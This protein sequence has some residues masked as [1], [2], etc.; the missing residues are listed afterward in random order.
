MKIAM[1]G[2]KGI[3]A[4]S[5]GVERYTENLSIR[6][7]GL[8]HSVYVYTRPYY[9][10]K[11]QKKHKSVNL[12]SIPSIHTKHLD[13]I[14]HTLFSSIHALFQNYD[15]IHY[16]GVGPS[17]LAWIPRIFKPKTKVIVTFHCRDSQQS[18]WGQFAKR[19]LNLGEWMACKFAHQVIVTSLVLQSYCKKKYNCDTIYIPNGV[20]THNAQRTTHNTQHIT[21]DTQH[22]AQITNF[23]NVLNNFNLEEKK[24]VL[25]VAR[26]IPDKGAH[27][28][29]KAF[30]S[31]NQ[32]NKFK[33]YKLVITGDSAFTDNYLDKI[34]KMCHDNQN[35]ILTGVLYGKNLEE[36]YKNAYAFV[37][38]STAEGLPT[39]VLEAMAYGIPVLTSNIPECMELVKDYGWSFENKDVQ[40]LEKKLEYLIN[41]PE[42]INEKAKKAQEFV[43]NNYNWDDLVKKVEKA[44]LKSIYN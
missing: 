32:N 15:I 24:Y 17:L 6:L 11:Y 8:G 21:Q 29:I 44:Y 40:D 7:A 22:T 42:V 35:I 33:D 16:H 31:L 9:V 2:Q 27:Y 4:L 37:L 5:G 14:S 19:M 43:L 20:N 1:I 41:N 36:L 23:N 38:P 28:L 39:V 10:F 13:A 12:I 26:L 34:K 25:M 18:K 3:P 30:K